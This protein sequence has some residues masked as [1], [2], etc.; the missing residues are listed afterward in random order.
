MNDDDNINWRGRYYQLLEL[1]RI[2]H[3]H[4]HDDVLRY[5]QMHTDDLRSARELREAV[6]RFHHD[7]HDA[8]LS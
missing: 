4:T 3:S 5:V 6:Q 2:H 8:G 1:L 7:I